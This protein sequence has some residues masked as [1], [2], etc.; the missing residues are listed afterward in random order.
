MNDIIRI[1][2]PL[3]A[4]LD[5]R[6]DKVG[7]LEDEDPTERCRQWKT[8]ECD[9]IVIMECKLWICRILQ[10]VCTMRLDIRLSLLLRNYREEW[11][12]GAW[13][14]EN[15]GENSEV[16]ALQPPLL[17]RGLRDRHL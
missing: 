4:L 15:T 7:Q 12:M 11:N 8:S 10:L 14:I 16:G 9:T 6:L 3:L 17:D 13:A 2:T 5:G 1:R